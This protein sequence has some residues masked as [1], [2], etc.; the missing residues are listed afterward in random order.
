MA[1]RTLTPETVFDDAK[2]MQ[3]QALERLDAGYLRDAAEKGWCATRR[4][5]EALILARTGKRSPDTPAVSRELRALG[6]TDEAVYRL[7]DRYG[8]TARFLHGECFYSG[9]CD[10]VENTE[11]RIREVAD[12]IAAAEDLAYPGRH[13]LR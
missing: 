7:E 3:R 6:R 5:A 4:A 2:D 1:T 12:F 13:D 10:P 9:L 8:A 11:R